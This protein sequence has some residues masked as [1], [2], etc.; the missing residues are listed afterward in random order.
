LVLNEKN[1]GIFAN[2][3]NITNLPSG[4]IIHFLS[5]DD[6]FK[7]SFLENV[8]KKIEGMALDPHGVRFILLPDVVIHFPDGSEQVLR[9]DP[10]FIAKYSATGLV[11]RDLARWRQVGISRALFNKWPLFPDNSEDVG[12]WADRIQHVILAQHIETQIVMDCQGAVY[13]AGVGIASRTKQDELEL[14]YC[15]SLKYLYVL[16]KNG[17]L[18]ISQEDASAILFLRKCSEI[19]IKFSYISFARIFLDAIKLL[20]ASSD[21]IA[22]VKLQ[23]PAIL[24]IAVSKSYIGNIIRRLKHK[25]RLVK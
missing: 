22:I 24:K 12:P 7:P 6:W 20:L 9:N 1:L 25:M 15:K 3:N 13:R 2:L 10:A 14:S 23:L 8:N 21:E 5:G 17:E 19:K 16:Y 4:D 11:I 18:N